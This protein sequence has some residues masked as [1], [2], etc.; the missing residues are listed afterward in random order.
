MHNWLLI[1]TAKLS[2][3]FDLQNLS[4]RKTDGMESDRIKFTYRYSKETETLLTTALKRLGLTSL[5]KLIDKL[6]LDA[7]VELPKEQNRLKKEI[8]SLKEE[9]AANREEKEK[10]EKLFN[11]LKFAVKQD[12]EN[13]ELIKKLIS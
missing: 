6:I 1:L 4:R 12:L 7:L 2:G 10:F 5:N 8:N 11:S 13:K 9:L 3:Q